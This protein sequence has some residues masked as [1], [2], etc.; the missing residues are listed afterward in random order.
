MSYEEQKKLVT[1]QIIPH[2]TGKLINF[3]I[4]KKLLKIII[5]FIILSIVGSSLGLIIH[6]KKNLKFQQTINKL[7]HIKKENIELRNK[8]NNLSAETQKLQ[9]KFN[10]L[11]AIDSKIKNIIGYEEV[12]NQVDNDKTLIHITNQKMNFSED[13]AEANLASGYANN[14]INSTENRLQTLKKVF[15]KKKEELKRLKSSVIKYKD[16][17]ASK[18]IGW[19]VKTKK[20][21]ITSDFGYRIHPVLDRRIMHE[22]LDIGVWYGTKVYATGAGKVIHAGWKNGYGKLVMID[23]GHGFRTLYGHN[24]RINVRVGEKVERGDLIAYSGNTGRSSGP[25]LHYEIQVNGK[26][27][28]PMD[29]IKQDTQE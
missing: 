12:N 1:I 28:N 6:Y 16:Y 22:G 21:R 7:D 29:Y 25:H 15:P 14:S 2:S 13:T 18:P 17:L 26:P 27:V 8:L 5:S 4:S 9:A 11:E 10:E 19:P 24:R 3:K 23:H 20:K